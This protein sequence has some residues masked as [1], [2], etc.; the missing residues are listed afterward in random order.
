[1]DYKFV[2]LVVLILALI[3]IITTGFNNIRIQ[4]SNMRDIILDRI[5]LNSE[6]VKIKVDNNIGRCIKEIGESNINFVEQIRKIDNITGQ[7]ITNGTENYNTETESNKKGDEKFSYFMS[8]VSHNNRVV[9]D[10]DNFKV[11]LGGNTEA[12]PKE[13]SSSSSSQQS[14]NKKINSTVETSSSHSSNSSSKSNSESASNHSEAESASNHSEAESASHHSNKSAS[15]HSNESGEKSASQQNK[16]SNI[17]IENSS[18]SSSSGTTIDFENITVGTA[19]SGKR[20]QKPPITLNSKYDANVV[21]DVK[22]L[23]SANFGRMESYKIEDLKGIARAFTIPTT[24]LDNI[25]K[26]RRQLKKEELYNKIKDLL[27][28]KKKSK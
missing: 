5:K 23:T 26:Q 4:L 27:I 19:A 18:N 28:N 21:V 13:T 9:S 22:N 12:E 15:H 3:Y 14:S 17:E 16:E 20:G 2:L 7:K 6:D 1:M 10:K 11:N 24:V 8:D 25:T